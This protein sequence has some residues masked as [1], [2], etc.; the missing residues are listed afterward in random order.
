MTEADITFAR[1][2][3][4]T[5]GLVELRAFLPKKWDSTIIGYY[6]DADPLVVDALRLSD[7]MNAS[8]VYVTANPP[9][10]ACR[11]RYEINTAAPRKSS[12]SDDEIERRTHLYVDADPERIEGVSATGAEK[13]A[14]R[15]LALQ[16]GEYLKGQGFAAPIF[17]DSGNGYHL[18]YRVDL[19]ADDGG[20]VA[21]LLKALS[22]RFSTDEVKI[23]TTVGNA[24]R[25][26]KLPGTIA[27]KGA[28]HEERPHR[29][30]RCL[31][32]PDE[33]ATTPEG[34]LRRALADLRPD[35]P[36]KP[37]M[38][39]QTSPV[40]VGAADGPPASEE[41]P[42]VLSFFDSRPDYDTWTKIIAGTLDRCGGDVHEAERYLI[43]AL[44]EEEEGEYRKK[45]ANPNRAEWSNVV[46]LAKAR[47]HDH[48]AYY[49]EWHAARRM[50]GHAHA[51]EDASNA[52]ATPVPEDAFWYLHKKKDKL[53]LKINQA[54][55]VDFIE[56]AGYT[57]I[58][59]HGADES[60]FVHIDNNVVEPVSGEQIKDHVLGYAET[61]RGDIGGGFDGSH[62]REQLL[63]GANAYF[64]AYL[65]TCMRP[66]E[67][68][69]KRDTRTA[70]W[71]F[72]RN[73]YVEI[74]VD[75]GEAETKVQPYSDL[76]GHIWRS[77]I[78]DREVNLEA[79]LAASDFYRFIRN[80][81][82]DNDERVMTMITAI[83]YLAHRFK[84]RAMA[85]AICLVDERISDDPNGRSGKSIIGLALSHS[86]ASARIDGRNFSFDT[87]F[88]FQ[89]IEHGTAVV[90][91][92]D[93]HKKFPFER[94]FSVI[95]DDMQIEKKGRDR[96]SIPFDESPKFL[97]TTN[98]VVDGEGSSHRDRIFEIELSDHYNERHK[99]IHDFGRLLFDEWDDDEWQR[100]DAFITYCLGSY[101]EHGLIPYAHKNLNERKLRQKTLP[102]FA[103]FVDEIEA[104]VEY[105]KARLFE[106]FTDAYPDLDMKQRTFTRWL[107]QYA[108]LY[109][110]DVIEDR[111]NTTV[112]GKTVNIR[113]IKLMEASL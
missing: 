38:S 113:T 106:R 107:K 79:D 33:V 56:E 59:P 39:A 58:Y 85:K 34:T 47:G 31:R 96:L 32:I 63:K 110:M 103:E 69:L 75:G 62:L 11:A 90:D 23:D 57:K 1:H 67:L 21:D 20:L 40:N 54:R 97:L 60:I 72:F 37:R 109:D 74:T 24:S 5:N 44:P 7:E 17:N 65:L 78:I 84:N 77:W 70:A 18:V 6:D 27:R 19:P 91:F 36:E 49:R 3:I 93:C 52:P 53:E 92:N 86:V 16:V 45:L 98:Y 29:R 8:A 101:L 88:A 2:L 28:N 46:N 100:F 108:A 22:A 25:I 13:E 111:T 12:T 9:V 4:R 48:S 94:L 35:V 42:H 61:L 89:S 55:L 99:P 71:R 68:N 43:A 10:D 83:G 41:V 82:A 81:S 80:V 51:A 26:M 104:G 73:G 95:T 105:D 64:G 76:D 14:A 87:Q 50:N 66:T 30:A 112:D 102:E 15:E